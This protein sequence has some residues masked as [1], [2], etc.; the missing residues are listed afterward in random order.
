[1]VARLPP[2]GRKEGKSYTTLRYLVFNISK[3]KN[4]PDTSGGNENCTCYSLFKKLYSNF[5]GNGHH[6]SHVWHV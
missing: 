1:M 2:R 3:F 4:P 5:A 6:R